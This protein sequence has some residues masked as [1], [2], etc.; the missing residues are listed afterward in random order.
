M[1][2]SEIEGSQGVGRSR[3]L[4]EHLLCA[5]LCNWHYTHHLIYS[6]YCYSK[7]FA[8]F[9]SLVQMRKSRW[10]PRQW[11]AEAGLR[12]ASP[13]PRPPKQAPSGWRTAQPAPQRGVPEAGIIPAG[14]SSQGMLHGGGGLGAGSWRMR[15]NAPGI[16]ERK[17][18]PRRDSVRKAQREMF[19]ENDCSGGREHLVWH[20]PALPA[21]SASTLAQDPGC[22]QLRLPSVPSCPPSIYLASSS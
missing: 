19:Q 18:F 6:I 12:S 20:H 9:F 14:H 15:R 8:I 4:S 13:P 22:Q 7:L 11:V 21:E 2:D 16:K 5:R 10:I 1:A 17:S 3:A